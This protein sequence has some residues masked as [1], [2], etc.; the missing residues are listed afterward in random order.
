M[1][2]C[3]SCNGLG[4]RCEDCPKFGYVDSLCEASY[5][6]ES[7]EDEEMVRKQGEKSKRKR[8]EDK[9]EVK[10]MK[11]WTYKCEVCDGEGIISGNLCEWCMCGS[12]GEKKKYFDRPCHFC[13]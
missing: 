11:A 10:K 7:E 4:L 2:K 9:K 5:D 8:S 1:V 13:G 6:Y 12:C 3:N